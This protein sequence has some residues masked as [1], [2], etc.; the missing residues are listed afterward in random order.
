MVLEV[1]GVR[2][3]ENKLWRDAGT[4]K[5]NMGKMGKGTG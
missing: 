1:T 5:Q 3:K 4:R 2:D